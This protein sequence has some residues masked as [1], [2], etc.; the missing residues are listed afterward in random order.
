LAAYYLGLAELVLEMQRRISVRR[1]LQ[2]K[3]ISSYI[4]AL[5]PINTTALS[6]SLSRI[7][8]TYQ[9]RSVLHEQNSASEG[10]GDGGA[11]SSTTE[12]STVGSGGGG[13][14]LVGGGASNGEGVVQI[15]SA[16]REQNEV[17]LRAVADLQQRLAR[18]EA[19]STAA[20]A[21]R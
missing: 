14:D 6:S 10:A 4:H 18:I 17:L 9:L 3:P 21:A 12:K 20:R 15:A 2:R 7:G 13:S 11:K 8:D 5:L 19:A 1:L 16:L